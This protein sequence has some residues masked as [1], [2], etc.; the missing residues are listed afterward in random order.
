MLSNVAARGKRMRRGGVERAHYGNKDNCINDKNEKK[1]HIIKK[2]FS[3]DIFFLFLQLLTAY[4]RGASAWLEVHVRQETTATGEEP[5]KGRAK[6]EKD[7]GRI[8]AAPKSQ[9]PKRKTN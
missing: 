8:P 7:G 2:K 5:K 6:S 4:P 1:F 3:I 9:N